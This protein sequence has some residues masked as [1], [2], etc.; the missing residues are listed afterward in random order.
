MGQLDNDSWMHPEDAVTSDNGRAVLKIEDDGRMCI[1]WDGNLVW[2]NT[3]E[4]RDDI[5]GLKLQDD[6]NLVL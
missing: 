2:Y 1:Y 3:E 5:Q 6:G 4:G